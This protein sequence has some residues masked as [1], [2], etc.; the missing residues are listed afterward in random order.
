MEL[1]LTI[2]NGDCRGRY[3]LS[4][5]ER[6]AIL[7]YLKPEH[8]DENL[9]I[10][11][12]ASVTPQE[13]GS[14]RLPAINNEISAEV[15][16]GGYR[17]ARRTIP[18][19]SVADIVGDDEGSVRLN[20]AVESME[21]DKGLCYVYNQST[22]KDIKATW[23]VND[24]PVCRSIVPLEKGQRQGFQIKKSI[25]LTIGT[26]EEKENCLFSHWTEYYE[27][28]FEDDLKSADVYA[29]LDPINRKPMYSVMN[30]KY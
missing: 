12:W 27:Y 24:Q 16:V 5:G 4:L 25:S 3:P 13:G 2:Y 15:S 6:N 29:W 1:R 30:C 14:F 19:Q 17:T 21:L 9:R 18:Q 26:P 8:E 7:V 23:F 11:P 20:E 10:L 22:C 28:V